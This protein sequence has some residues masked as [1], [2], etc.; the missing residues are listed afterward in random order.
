MRLWR[1]EKTAD[2]L[3]A[4]QGDWIFQGNV[5][6]E[7]QLITFGGG[8]RDAIDYL[9]REVRE[10]RIPEDDILLAGSLSVP[11]EVEVYLA[12]AEA[13]ERGDTSNV[14]DAYGQNI[15]KLSGRDDVKGKHEEAMMAVWKTDA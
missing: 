13:A 11:W 1:K 14:F 15:L 10:G 6:G 8:W 12:A 5:A 3:P 9:D 7:V 4:D 2:T